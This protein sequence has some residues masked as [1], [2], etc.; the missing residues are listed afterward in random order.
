MY[1]IHLNLFPKVKQDKQDNTTFSIGVTFTII[2]LSRRLPKT[3]VISP[4]KLCTHLS[5]RRTRYMPR[6]SHSPQQL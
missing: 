3:E 5:S 2:S 6:P 1:I 4:P